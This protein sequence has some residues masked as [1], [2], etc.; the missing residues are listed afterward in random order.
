[1]IDENAM[2]PKPPY[3]GEVVK[4]LRPGGGDRSG[5]DEVR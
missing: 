3:A 1:M 5:L 4:L 2:S